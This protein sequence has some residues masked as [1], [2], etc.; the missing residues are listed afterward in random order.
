MRLKKRFIGEES[1]ASL[2]LIALMLPLLLG[3]TGA[4]IDLGRLYAVRSR[5]QGALDAALLGAVAT[6][7]TA[8]VST[9]AQQ[10][11]NAN[12]PGT[13]MGTAASGVSVTQSGSTY[14][15]STRITVPSSIM[16]LFGHDRTTLNLTS[17]VTNGNAGISTEIAMVLDNSATVNVSS[18]ILASR[19]FINTLLRGRP[20]Q[21][22]IFVSVLPY[23]V[24]VNTG[25]APLTRL[26]WAQDPVQYL[27]YGGGGGRAYFANRNPD[28]PPD[29]NFVDVSDEPPGAS[30]TTRF[31]TPYGLAPGIFNNGDGVSRQ[32]S[33]MLFASNVRTELFVALLR[34]RAG[35]RTRHNVGLMW[36]WFAL[37]PRWT[38]R[39]DPGKPNLPF[40]AAPTRRKVIILVAGSRNNVYLG[41]N[42][43]CGAGT[44]AVSDDDTT[45]SQ[46]CTAIRQQDIQVYTIGFGPPANYNAAQLSACSSGPGYAFS[47][48]NS[49]QLL[50]AYRSI[51]DRLN[52]SSVRLVQ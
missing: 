25:T 48:T 16:Q 21:P 2:I 6:A 32:I 5:A 28:I 23:D 33:S 42:Q 10:L 27:L 13:Y 18:I 9:E 47:A 31:R 49:T 24:A 14:T 15:A 38:G 41:V 46:L 44:C 3:V 50:A 7:N 30:P 37:S 52:Y 12:F 29:A 39:W 4:T 26:T 43:P 20:S 35:G 45:F 19:S 36:G 51:I 22:D 17:M 1:G 8:N 40:V 11:F 34:M